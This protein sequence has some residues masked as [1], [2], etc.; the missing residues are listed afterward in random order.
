V[1]DNLHGLESLCTLDLSEN[2]IKLVEG[3]STLTNLTTLN[4]SKNSL[5]NAASIEHLAECNNLS[6]VDL[7]HNQLA[8]ANIVE[9]IAGISKLTSLGMSGNPVCS[10]VAFFRKK[11]I[12][13]NKS[14]RYLDRPV[15]DNERETAEEWARAGPEAE[16]ELKEKLLAMKRD[17]ERKATQ[18]FRQWQEYVRASH[19]KEA[20]TNNLITV[21]EEIDDLVEIDGETGVDV[22]TSML[23]KEGR[24]T[25]LLLE[26]NGQEKHCY[27]FNMTMSQI[28]AL[29]KPNDV[30]SSDDEND[31]AVKDRG[32]R[33]E[34]D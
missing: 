31:D 24:I 6:A 23:E 8:G 27:Q 22:E 20:S 18:E 19:V 9:C 3:L 7:S 26:Q 4:L 29:S 11:M 33:S 5:E 1:I 16:R 32:E 17:E 25:P 21:L 13:A 34:H 10:K 30:V 15:F 28:G 2:K 14:L 12:V